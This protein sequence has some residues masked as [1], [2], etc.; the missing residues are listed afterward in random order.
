MSFPWRH[1]VTFFP[2]SSITS[3]KYPLP[4][5][6]SLYPCSLQ[7]PPH[8][9]P[10]CQTEWVEIHYNRSWEVMS[11]MVFLAQHR[12]SFCGFLILGNSCPAPRNSPN[13]ILWRWLVVGKRFPSIKRKLDPLPITGLERVLTQYVTCRYRYLF[14]SP[15]SHCWCTRLMSVTGSVIHTSLSLRETSLCLQRGRIFRSHINLTYYIV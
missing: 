14:G 8:A 7:T 12:M 3:F 4:P 10:N 15:L 6:L 1:V 13:T 11:P 9:S 5:P 2:L